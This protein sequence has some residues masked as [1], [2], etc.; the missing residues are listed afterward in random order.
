MDEEGVAAEGKTCLSLNP[1]DQGREQG[2]GLAPPQQWTCTLSLL[3]TGERM[4][5]SNSSREKVKV[6]HLEN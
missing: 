1:Q 3:P 2:M 4:A 6:L 5:V